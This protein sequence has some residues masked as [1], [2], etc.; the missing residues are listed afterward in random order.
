MQAA[1]SIYLTQE[2]VFLRIHRQEAIEMNIPPEGSVSYNGEIS[3]F[4]VYNR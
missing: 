2:E 1:C 3:C 4:E